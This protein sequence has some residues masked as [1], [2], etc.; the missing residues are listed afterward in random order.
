MSVHHLR[1]MADYD[2][3]PLWD[4]DEPKN[5]D[6]NSL[7]LSHSLIQD[8]I[9]WAERFNN[10]LD[11]ADPLNSAFASRGDEEQ[12]VHDG[13]ELATRVDSELG[14]AYEVSYAQP[15]PPSSQTEQRA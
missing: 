4:C 2:S 8:L 10:T 9:D 6:P 5:V 13:A 11:R 1:L 7:P 3:W 15:K 14:P 12:F